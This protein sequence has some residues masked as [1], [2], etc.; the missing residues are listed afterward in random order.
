MAGRRPRLFGRAEDEPGRLLD[1]LRKS[2]FLHPSSTGLN[3][4]FPLIGTRH[5]RPSLATASALLLPLVPREP[6]G[7]QSGA[8]CRSR[9]A[10][11]C[12]P[13]DSLRLLNPLA[14]WIHRPLPAGGGR[15]EQSGARATSSLWRPL[16]P[17]ACV[18]ISWPALARFR[19][20]LAGRSRQGPRPRA[21]CAPSSTRHSP[22]G[23]S[24]GI[25]Q[26]FE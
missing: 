10:S 9:P 17:A 2:V 12:V 11:P 16:V 26:R 20:H 8:L 25:R 14:G 5:A 7:V 3:W 24:V 6:L 13:A 15:S 1:R 22:R 19:F 21:Q 23:G 18:A 4:G